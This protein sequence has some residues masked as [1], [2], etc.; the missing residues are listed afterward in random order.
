VLSPNQPCT[1]NFFLY[2][3]IHHIEKSQG[4]VKQGLPAKQAQKRYNEHVPSRIT[5]VTSKIQPLVEHAPPADEVPSN[6]HQDAHSRELRPQPQRPTKAQ[7]RPPVTPPSSRGARPVRAPPPPAR[8]A[9]LGGSFV[10]VGS[11]RGR[12]CSPTPV[13]GLRNRSPTINAAALGRQ[14]P[15]GA[16]RAR[17]GRRLHDG[18]RR[19]SRRAVAPT[20]ALLRAPRRSATD[21]LALHRRPPQRDGDEP[22]VMV[23]GVRLRRCRIASA[24]GSLVFA[25]STAYSGRGVLGTRLGAHR[26]ALLHRDRDRATAGHPIQHTENHRAM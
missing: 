14:L 18:G 25:P 9:A 21:R 16:F 24:A 17:G 15:R 23:G 1:P 3:L 22:L 10:T 5:L 13:A 4:P 7:A 26:V 6:R 11:S 8:H 19:R 2:T 12:A 20:G